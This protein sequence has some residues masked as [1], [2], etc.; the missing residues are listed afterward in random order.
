MVY[1]LRPYN[2]Y[3]DVNVKN[4]I[5]PKDALW[6]TPVM[7]IS[8]STINL[9]SLPLQIVLLHNAEGKGEAEIQRVVCIAE[10]NIDYEL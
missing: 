4:E 5:V 1:L 9:I 6:Q 3:F 7:Y 2:I 8:C 10:I